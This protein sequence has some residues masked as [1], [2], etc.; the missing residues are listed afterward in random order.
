MTNHAL[1]RAQE[2]YGL[3]LTQS[4]LRKMIKDLPRDGFIQANYDDGSVVWVTR[5]E[6]K[7]IRLIVDARSKTIL[8]FLPMTGPLSRKRLRGEIVKFDKPQGYR[9]GKKVYGNSR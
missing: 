1:D 6:G 8:T 4:D 5:W 2:R 9:K 7:L 3:E